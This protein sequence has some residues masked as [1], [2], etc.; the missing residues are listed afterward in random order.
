MFNIFL[1]EFNMPLL[2]SFLIGLGIGLAIAVLFYLILVLSSVRKN[3]IVVKSTDNNLT[4]E[5][6]KLMIQEAQQIFKDKSLKGA[7]SNL[8]YCKDLSYELI[9]N[10][11]R[12]YYPDSKRP[13][14]ELS[15]DEVLMLTVYISNRLDEI[16]DAK[17]LRLFRKLKVSQIIGMTEIKE[18][19]E[20]NSIVKAT[21][22]YKIFEAISAAK[23]VVNIVNPVYW[24]RKAVIDKSLNFAIKKLCLIIIATCGEETYKIYSKAVFDTVVDI[25]SGIDKLV[26]D[27]QTDLSEQL[28]SNDVEV[29]DNKDSSKEILNNRILLEE[30]KEL[31]QTK[32]KSIFSILKKGKDK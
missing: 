18:K 14:Y 12:K 25:D 28:S 20:A 3:N 9:L 27:I 17:G 23:K 24:A 5:E 31:K 15:I 13:L 10:I 7:N 30:P 1:I 8:A 2:F 16:L 4:D 29:V 21:K 11:A 32:K 22:K 26:S 19:I 6:V